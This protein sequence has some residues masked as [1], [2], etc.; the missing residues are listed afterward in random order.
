M[1]ET[2]PW[3]NRAGS[4]KD[5]SGSVKTANLSVERRVEYEVKA[6]PEMQETLPCKQ[7]GLPRLP[8]AL[9]VEPGE[10]FKPRMPDADAPPALPPD[11]LLA[12]LLPEL[13]DPVTV[14]ESF[15][16]GWQSKIFIC[17]WTRKTRKGIGHGFS[18]IKRIKKEFINCLQLQLEVS[19]SHKV[20]GALAQTCVGG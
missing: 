2:A 1:F 8:R 12:L 20:K 7:G 14:H 6:L 4:L 15:I 9:H 11:L 16:D 19:D 10:L 13:P 18:R 5:C 17:G 3:P